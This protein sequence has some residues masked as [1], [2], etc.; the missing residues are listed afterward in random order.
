MVAKPSGKHPDRQPPGVAVARLAG[1]Q[2]GIVDGQDLEALGLDRYAVARLVGAG[3]LQLVHPGV[4]SVGHAPL[5]LRSRYLAAVKACGPGA[6][7]SHRSAADLWGLRPSSSR[8]EVTVGRTRRDVAGVVVHHSRLLEA[9]DVTVRDGI[10][11]TTVARALL[12]LAGAVPAHHLAK[13]LDR[14]ERA[15]LS[16]LVAFERVLARARGKPGARALRVSI[17]AWRPRY[18]KSELENRFAGLVERS[19]LPEPQLNAMVDGERREHEVDAYWPHH[20]LAVQ[21]DSFAF[22]RTRRDIEHDA[23]SDADLE[24]AG[25]GVLRLSED[26]LAVRAAVTLRRLERRL[27][28]PAP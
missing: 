3:W 12:D 11:V 18:T 17:E 19:G 28:L 9:E 4:H 7:L 14:A 23:A 16:D 21:V 20:R 1:R 8:I 27:T 26:D 15:G 5:S 25:K 24:L 10:P 6:A 2:H 13:A 22:H